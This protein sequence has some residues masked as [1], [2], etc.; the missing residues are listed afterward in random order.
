M[1]I[2]IT[3]NSWVRDGDPLIITVPWWVGPN[4]AWVAK[5]MKCTVG[6]HCADSCEQS[7]LSAPCPRARGNELQLRR[8]RLRAA[9][10]AMHPQGCVIKCGKVQWALS[11]RARNRNA[12]AMNGNGGL[13]LRIA[14]IAAC[15]MGCAMKCEKP[16]WFLSR[17]ARNRLVHA[18]NG[19]TDSAVRVS[20][21][22][23]VIAERL[24]TDG[25]AIHVVQSC[26][27]RVDSALRKSGDSETLARIAGY[28]SAGNHKRCTESMRDLCKRLDIAFVHLRRPAI[29]KDGKWIHDHNRRRAANR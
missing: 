2:K 20:T 27:D 4:Q 13:Q 19:N 18:L 26:I 24:I 1:L 9:V 5:M 25:A 29:E 15:L 16:R 21:P 14:V 12:H 10:R 11:R 17:R 8:G 28:A 22:R 6:S 7:P 23:E 3:A